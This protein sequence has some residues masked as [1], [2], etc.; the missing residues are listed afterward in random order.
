MDARGPPKSLSAI[1]YS[2]IAFF[3]FY[4]I[5]LVFFLFS[6]A[7]GTLVS[8]KLLYISR[9]CWDFAV[10]RFSAFSFWERG[11]VSVLGFLGG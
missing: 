9:F 2:E 6:T 10:F 1:F 4:L 7:P 11:W 8:I 3:P 5:F